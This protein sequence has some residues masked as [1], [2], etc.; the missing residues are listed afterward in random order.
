[1][2]LNFTVEEE[3]FRTEIQGWI[4][5]NL[6]DV[7]R[8]SRGSST[9]A[10][11]VEWYKKL[12]EKGC[13]CTSWP[14]DAGGTGWSLAKQYIFKDEASKR[15]APTS[16]MGVTMIGPLLIEYGTPEQKERYLPKITA[17]EE[18]WCQGYSEPNAGSDLANL[19]LK[20]IRD[21]DD[22][23]LDGQ[24]TWTSGADE[25]DMIFILTRTNSNLERKQ[26]GITFMVASMDSPGIETRPIRQI[27]D[28]SHFCETFFTEVRVP[29]TNVIGD[30]DMGWTLA[31]KLLAHERISIGSAE[32][33]RDSLEKVAELAHTAQ[34][35]GKPAIEND[36]IRQRLANCFIQ[37]DALRAI[38][39]R[40]LTNALRGT[41]PGTESSI[42]KLFGSEILQDITDLA[43]D[44]QGPIAKLWGDH[45]MGDIEN[46]WSKA[47][48]G[49]RAYTIFSGTSEVQR[50][51][52]SERVLGMPKG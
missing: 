36:H 17:A 42:N 13:L 33:Y 1:M 32:Y 22:Y 47:A 28:D 14:E 27:T 45:A 52:I 35:D 11:R 15:G 2:D 51:I 25:S 21:G 43:Q 6:P 9:R 48:T 46:A 8:N 50:N 4:E 19:S 5:E 24:K 41:P 44:I 31:K 3:E 37:L 20:A 29:A 10:D 26:N 16:D 18:L 30:E 38:G 34:I 40:G 7:F 39:F 49:S 23:I 12:G